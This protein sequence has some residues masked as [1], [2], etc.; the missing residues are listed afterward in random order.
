MRR[1][2]LGSQGPDI[3]VIGLGAWEA[4]GEDW[5]PNDSEESVIAALRTAFDTGIDWVDTAEV[6][7]SGVS[8]TLVGRAVAGRR[9][10]LVVA[11][12]VAPADEGSGFRPEEVQKA[13][14]SSL[15][16]LGIDHIDLYQL[17]WPDPFGTAVEDTWGAMCELQD[18]GKVRWIGVSNFDRD[19]IERCEVI[20]HV[21]SLQPEFS[22]VALG[23]RD[24]IRW[25]GERGIGVVTYSPIGAGLLTGVVSSPAAFPEG[26]WRQE[27]EQF[28][29]GNLERNLAL[30]EAMRPIS[31]RLGL[32]L[33]QLALAWNVA[34]P[35]VTSAIAGSRNP[36]HVKENAAA[37]DVV[38]DAATFEELE[39][40][41]D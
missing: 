26:D 24:L 35:G 25:C 30:V 28:R 38:L 39:A 18:A 40:L 7:G 15:A 5:G 19:L 2:R 34:Q 6:Y 4:G 29:P 1:R 16:R 32:T 13:C 14:D 37:G 22:V 12:K 20:R 31:E 21:D 10:D 36:T 17:H 41:L 23:E 33:P 3:S 11:S 27:A 9:D 8:E